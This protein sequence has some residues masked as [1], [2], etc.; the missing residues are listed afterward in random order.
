MKKPAEKLYI[1]AER[2]NP[3]LGT[4]LSA[5]YV[6]TRRNTKSSIIATFDYYG[7]KRKLKFERY[8]NPDSGAHCDTGE[9]E[10]AYGGMAY[11][12]FDTPDEALAY[13]KAHWQ[14][15]YNYGSAVK[16]LTA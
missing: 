13:L 11:Y 6:A 3:Q 5:A 16:A 1:I 4:Y 10:C 12:G 7:D 9:T 8:K 15:H 14:S 2:L